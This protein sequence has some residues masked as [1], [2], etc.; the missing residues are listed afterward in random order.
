MS[1][2]PE[3]LDA[4]VVNNS[5]GVDIGEILLSNDVAGDTLE[6]NE[7]GPVGDLLGGVGGE[8]LDGL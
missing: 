6:K 8:V 3:M 2:G 1:V 5:A 7:L 4:V